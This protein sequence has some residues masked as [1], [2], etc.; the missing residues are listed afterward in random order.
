M[1][2]IST[3][4]TLLVGFVGFAVGVGFVPFLAFVIA[5][6]TPALIAEPIA[7]VLFKLNLVGMGP[8]T[9]HQTENDAYELRRVDGEFH[10][11]EPRK[12]TRWAWQRIGFSFDS[13]PQAW[14]TLY[15][16]PEFKDCEPV[17]ADDAPED[18]VVSKLTRGGKEW[19]AQYNADGLRVRL[20]AALNRLKGRSNLEIAS[21]S[22][23]EGLKEHGGDTNDLSI[24]WQAGGFMFLFMMSSAMGFVV[25]F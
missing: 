18:A 3:I 12:W 19:Y 4:I 25:F 14:G 23:S 17:M 2:S 7:N 22:L 15:A 1:I 10:D 11:E 9:I 8:S 13:T 24:K 5:S 21:R 6:A 16:E 20:G